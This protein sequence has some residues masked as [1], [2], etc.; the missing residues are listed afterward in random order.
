VADINVAEIFRYAKPAAQLF[1]AAPHVKA[2]LDA[3]HARPAF[4]A[5][6][7]ARDA[8]AA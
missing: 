1:A 4:Q 3:C 6:W 7:T 8:E 5:M 2:W